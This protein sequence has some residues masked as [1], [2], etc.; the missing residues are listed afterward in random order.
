MTNHLKATLKQVMEDW[1]EGEADHPDR[2]DGYIHDKLAD[3]M[4]SA[5][6]AVY[7]ANFDGQAFADREAGR[8]E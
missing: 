1:I 3:Q 8:T 4:A 7:D 5:A 2:P 6:A